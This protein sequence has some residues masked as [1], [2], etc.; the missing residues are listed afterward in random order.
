MSRVN[1]NIS[2]HG[3]QTAVNINNLQHCVGGG[4]NRILLVNS[5]FLFVCESD[6]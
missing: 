3:T 5:H 1:T 2:P 4:E 6:G